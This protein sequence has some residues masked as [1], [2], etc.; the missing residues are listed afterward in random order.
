MNGDEALLSHEDFLAIAHNIFDR[1]PFLSRPS[2]K[3][4]TFLAALHYPHVRSLV[5]CPGVC[6]FQR[7]TTEIDTVKDVNE[8]VVHAFIGEPMPIR[9]IPT[10]IVAIGTTMTI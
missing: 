4:K 1:I 2:P 9:G 3:K 5:V 10:W 7:V 8:L 6:E